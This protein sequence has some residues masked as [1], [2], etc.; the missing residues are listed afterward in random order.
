MGSVQPQVD[1][2]RQEQERLACDGPSRDHGVARFIS[3]G[4]VLL[5]RPP[6]NAHSAI[7]EIF[8][9][10]LERF[11]ST[12]DAQGRKIEVTVVD[13]PDQ[14]KLP[15]G[16][17]EGMVTSYANYLLVNGGIIV[18]RFGDDET[19][20]KALQLFRHLF[21]SRKITQVYI[22]IFASLFRCKMILWEFIRY[23][24][25]HTT[26]CLCPGITTKS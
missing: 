25:N 16:C 12:T 13:E 10:A 14:E 24:Q 4:H 22:N 19:D 18:P 3:A 7:L 1:L 15:G 20:Q 9:D 5:S 23:N 6:R 8:N 17:V 2:R 11:E 26:V 21:P